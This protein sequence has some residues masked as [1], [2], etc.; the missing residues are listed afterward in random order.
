MAR[1]IT[2]YAEI[3]IEPG[4]IRY[5]LEK[6]M[7]PGDAGRPGPCWLD[8]PVDVQSAM[9]EELARAYDPARRTAGTR[10]CREQAAK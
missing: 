2:K 3:V 5:Q 1:R 7:V 9:V 10:N 4:C 6:A 8:I